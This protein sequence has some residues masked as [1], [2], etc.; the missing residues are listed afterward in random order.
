MFL[1]QADEDRQEPNG[2][3]DQSQAAADAEP[4]YDA[5]AALDHLSPST[6]LECTGVGSSIITAA[7]AIARAGTLMVVGVG[8]SK[9]NEIPF[10]HLSLREIKL[11]FINRYT[12]TWPAGMN[13]MAGEALLPAMDQ[14]ITARFKL[15]DAVKA[16]EL[17]GGRRDK[18]GDGGGES[19][20]VVK[21]MIKDDLEL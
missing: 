8:A 4:V 7:H 11:K 1:F 9:I 13:A 10:M 2:H 21:V 20:V 15:E 12:D 17:V 14:L 5:D 19:G 18:Q 16:L 6:V 3:N